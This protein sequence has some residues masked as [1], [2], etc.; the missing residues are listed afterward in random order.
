MI[1]IR[2]QLLRRSKHFLIISE[3]WPITRQTSWKEI[4][5]G[6]TQTT[7]TKIGK[8][9]TT[10]S[11]KNASSFAQ[12]DSKTP[13][14]YIC[15]KVRHTLTKYPDK[16]KVAKLLRY[17]WDEQQSTHTQGNDSEKSNKSDAKEAGWI[18]LHM[19]QVIHKQKTVH[20][21]KQEGG[22]LLHNGLT[23]SIFINPNLVED[24]QPAYQTLSLLTNAGVQQCNKE[25]RMPGFGTIWFHQDTIA[26]IY[27]LK[28]FKELTRVT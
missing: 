5:Q 4:K 1:S 27:Y 15:G 23:L 21:F 28:Q 3:I 17:Y 9:T 8:T 24:I 7:R 18:G 22:I 13:A 11:N 16:D 2:Q 19:C 12:K 6:Q 10:K 25:A 20:V 26:N 14:Y